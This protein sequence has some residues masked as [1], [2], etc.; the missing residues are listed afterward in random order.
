MSSLHDFD[1]VVKN[2]VVITASDEVRCDIGIKDGI[3]KVLAHDLPIGPNTK[4]ID[5]EGGYITVSYF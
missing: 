1:I 3:I 5:A 4:V 2:G